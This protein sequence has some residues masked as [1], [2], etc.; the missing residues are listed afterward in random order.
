M[1]SPY[2]PIPR[3]KHARHPEDQPV[4]DVELL[5][6]EVGEKEMNSLQSEQVAKIDLTVE[7]QHGIFERGDH[8]PNRASP[9]LKDDPPETAAMTPQT[10]E[11]RN[12]DDFTLFERQ[13]SH[14][15]DDSSVNTDTLDALLSRIERTKSQ[16]EQSASSKPKSKGERSKSRQHFRGLVHDLSK[17][18]EEMERLEKRRGVT[19]E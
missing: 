16:M 17:A 15:R 7:S 6:Q 8:E 11:N 13:K 10:S 2:R 19:S 5:M 9:G 1:G 12:D 4:I 18:A 3:N 14:S